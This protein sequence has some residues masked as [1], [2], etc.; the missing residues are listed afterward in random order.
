MQDEERYRNAIRY[1]MS[2][3]EEKRDEYV[4]K[5]LNA[6]IEGLEKALDKNLIAVLF[7]KKAGLLDKKKPAA[8]TLYKN[9]TQLLNEL[10]ENDAIIIACVMYAIKEK[11]RD[12]VLRVL[13]IFASLSPPPQQTKQKTNQQKT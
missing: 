9:I 7:D 8:E 13:S 6:V 12:T 4:T 11:F 2:L 5:V 3:P 1:L 10:K